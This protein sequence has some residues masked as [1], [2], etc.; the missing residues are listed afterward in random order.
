M[1]TLEAAVTWL[2]R[3]PIEVAQACDSGVLAWAWDMGARGARRRELRIWRGS[4]EICRQS[5]G[6]RGGAEADEA[7][8]MADILPSR[9]VRSAELWRRLALSRQ[10]LAQLIGAGELTVLRPA[11]ETAGVNATEL[12]SRDSV[13]K[14]LRNRRVA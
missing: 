3:D 6:A 7:T 1:L 2:D 12:I 9:D 5:R 13:V 4:V 8:V 11:S 14:M 10:R